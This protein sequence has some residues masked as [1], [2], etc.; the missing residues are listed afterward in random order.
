V[1]FRKTKA[2]VGLDIGS[3]AVKA[4]ELKPA[5]KAYKVTAF[6]SEPV[7]PDSIV[8]GAIIDGGA[9]AEAI[10]RLF[11][12]RGIK[13]REVAASLSGNAVIVK[14]ITL[15]QMTAAELSE[16]I[17][18]EAEQYIPFDIQDVNLDYQILDSGNGPGGKGS[19]DVLLVAA[20]KE[21][22]ADY[23][24]VIAQAG[25]SAV[26]VDVDAF[27]LQNAYEVNYGI[28]PSKVVVLL[29][30]G[31]S[32]TNI[33]IIQGD[34]SVFT[35][36]VSIGGNAYTEALQKELNLPFEHADQLKRGHAADGVTFEEAKPVL[37][38][39]T[40]NVMLEIQKTFDFFKATAASD[41]ID[42]I[43]V[44]GGASRAEA[45]TE[46]LTERF[47]TQVEA[48]DPFK[49][50]A[51]DSKKYPSDTVA[52]ISPTVAVAVGLALRRVGDR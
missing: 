51:L 3:S 21:K 31:A 43:V 20:K 33:N 17:Y 48:F 49:R 13:T 11:D 40:E 8:D 26:V 25:R 4:V 30:A 44:S 1:A 5:G 10:R 38:A 19:M 36:D 37:R 52:E 16:S 46:M 39:V 35:R 50:V 2:L 29:N 7:P 32:A 14:K 12:S 47:E 18:W 22:I 6:G 45:F 28:E 42:R 41:R 27:A 9:V 24:G 15:P 34:Q 23:T